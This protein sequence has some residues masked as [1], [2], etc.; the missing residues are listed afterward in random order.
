MN[1]ELAC[2]LIDEYLEDK[3]NWVDR[4]RLE[5]H[6]AS[7]RACSEELHGRPAL[8]RTISRA[9]TASVQHLKLSPEASARIVR[10]TQGSRRRVVWSNRVTV[11][12]RVLASAA[13]A[14]LV[15]MGVLLVL[16]RLSLPDGLTEYLP[17]LE[18]RTA[19]QN[20]AAMAVSFSANDIYFEPPHM[21]PGEPFTI[22][23]YFHS[24]LPEPVD[25]VQFNL[26]VEGPSGDYTF[27]LAAR[28]PLPI[29]GVSSVQVTPELLA[30]P[31][32]R[33]YQIAPIEIFRVPGV[34][35]LRAT[36]FNPLSTPGQ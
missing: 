9:L 12:V 28:G 33:Q 35:T 2:R 17:F 22:T 24:N 4:N 3:L 16:G 13:A 23:V 5:S 25:T 31:C 1:C 32:E 20:E 18:D 27:A 30:A 14:V 11:G 8:E 34:Y 21:Q 15:F 6:L 7:C 26:D 36:L 29:E 10:R 19:G